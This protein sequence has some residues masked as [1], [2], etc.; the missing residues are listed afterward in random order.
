MTTLQELAKRRGAGAMRS[1]K[2]MPA[3]EKRKVLKQWELFL[4][5]G[6]EREK[7]T[8]LLYNHLIQH[9]SFIAHYDIHGFYSTYFVEGEDTVHFL[10]QFDGRDGI[11]ESV[12]YHMT[13]WITNEEYG[14][15]NCEMV[16]I[17]SKY[18]PRLMTASVNKQMVDDVTRAK[19]LLEKHGIK[20]EEEKGSELKWRLSF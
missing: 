8:K 14:D 7:F 6:L 19:L 10:S 11:P 4:K 5:S 9:C 2:F 18:I 15:I 17:A 13:G 12:E 3:E 16:R 20:V 1:V